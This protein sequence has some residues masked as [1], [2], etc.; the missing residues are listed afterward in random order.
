MR[1]RRY[2]SSLRTGGRA[3]RNSR[4]H[5]ARAAADG[6]ALPP[7]DRR[8]SYEVVKLLHSMYTHIKAGDTRTCAAR[9]NRVVS[10]GERERNAR[11]KRAR[12]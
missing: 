5:V 8:N 1:N 6:Q 11:S 7:P 9:M 2:I 12:T 4:R 10:Q 3:Y